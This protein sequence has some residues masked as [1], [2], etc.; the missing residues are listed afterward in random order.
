LAGDNTSLSDLAGRYAAA[1]LDL[2]DEKKA[3]D[4]VSG[5]LQSLRSMIAESEDLRRLL[6]SPV[7]TREEQRK[8]MTAVMDRAGIGPLTRNFVLVV[9]RNH[10]LFAL[11]GMIE[12]YLAELARRRGEITAEVTSARSLSDAQQQALVET[13]RAS[14]GG[15]VQLNLKVDPALIGGLIVKVGSRMIDSSL[16]SKLQRLQLAMKGVG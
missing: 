1:L 15:K 8:A 6:N 10:R 4:Q 16:R 13:L 5:D 9:A 12:A 14:V 7:I 2:A 3:L 11:S